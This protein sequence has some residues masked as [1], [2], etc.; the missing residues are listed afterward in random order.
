DEQNTYE[1]IGRATVAWN[2]I[3]LVWGLI[4]VALLDAPRS[5]ADAAYHALRNFEA[6]RQ[7]TMALATERLANTSTAYKALA[8]LNKKLSPIK[9]G[10]NDIAHTKYVG[11][12]GSKE[13]EIWNVG[14][15]GFQGK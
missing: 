1:L 12:Y 8:N 10:R 14:R 6:Q 7:M 3:E 11:A 9:R 13:L 15:S 4:F 5:Q 2:D